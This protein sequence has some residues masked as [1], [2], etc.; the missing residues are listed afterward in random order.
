[1]DPFN[2]PLLAFRDLQ[3]AN[4]T[5]DDFLKT[6]PSYYGFSLEGALSHIGVLTF[7]ESL[8]YR[9]D[10]LNEELC[11]LAR[12][13]QSGQ[14]QASR[15]EIHAADDSLPSQRCHEGPG[16]S[17]FRSPEDYL[18][19]LRNLL[20]EQDLLSSS[21][22]LC[23]DEGREFW[24]LERRF[25]SDPVAFTLEDALKTSRLKSFDVRCLHALFRRLERLEDD[26]A[27]L[28]F[29]RLD[30]HLL[31][32]WHHVPLYTYYQLVLAPHMIS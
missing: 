32:R 28:A 22:G 15:R 25:Q 17:L 12:E 26:G 10:C 4:N 16:A 19:W 29:L 24:S 5:L 6:Y 27:L 1:M 13:R 31:V 8:I 21:V 11:F 9:A 7:V 23:L 30:E 2:F 3:K 20:D 14:K 18:D